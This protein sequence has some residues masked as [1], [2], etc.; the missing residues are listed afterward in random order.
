MHGWWR[1]VAEIGFFLPVFI[2]TVSL[3]KMAIR[4]SCIIRKDMGKDIMMEK[5]LIWEKEKIA[6]RLRSRPGYYTRYICL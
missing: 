2:Y 5:L 3:Q 6:S 4:L 1:R